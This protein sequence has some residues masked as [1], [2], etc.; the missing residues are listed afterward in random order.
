MSYY[1][2]DLTN[3]QIGA[4]VGL[5]VVIAIGGSVI[6]AGAMTLLSISKK[7]AEIDLTR[8]E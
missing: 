1:L 8:G 6:V 7:Q 3:S 5:V 4:I 2:S